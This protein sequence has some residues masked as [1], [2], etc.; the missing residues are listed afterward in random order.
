MTKTKT[1]PGARLGTKNKNLMASLALLSMMIPGLTYLLINNY[2]PMAGIVV[3]FK[4]F[5]YSKGIWGSD[6]AGLKNFTYLFKTQDAFNI[7]RNTVCY[8]IVF[9]FLNNTCAVAVAIML[10]FL[11]GKMNKK[12]YQTLILIPYLIS[13]VVVSYIGYGFL[14]QESGYLNKLLVSLGFEPIS[15]YAEQKY[16]PFILVIINLWKGIGYSSIMYYATVIGIDSALYE[17][18]SIDGANV[19]QQVWH[20]TLPALR[21]TI[22]IMVLLALGRM[23]Y[24]DFGLFYQVPMHSGLLA[25]VTDTIDVFTYKALTQLND[26]GRAAAAGFL[27]SVLGFLMVLGANFVVSKIDPDNSLF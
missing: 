25:D 22:I 4:N 15:W 12:V 10:N 26:V 2:L 1:A 14:S 17:A 3:A 24:S 23:F 13:M 16:W 9:I 19:W 27:Q 8:N 21:G 5:N 20:V 7:V 11:R 18:A 6:W